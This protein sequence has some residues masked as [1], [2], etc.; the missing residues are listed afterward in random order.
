MNITGRPIY[1]KGQKGEPKPRKQL[2]AKPKKVDPWLAKV[3][4]LPCIICHEFGEQQL[5]RTTVHHWIMDRGSN[6]R[7]PHKQA[8]P[9]CDG[10]HQGDH[11]TSKVAI[12]REPKLWR[13]KYG[14]DHEYSAWVQDIIEG[15]AQL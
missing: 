6:R 13:E 5:S 3:A 15:T 12:H 10:H 8:L 14:A 9:L 7:T 1:Q 4:E 11:D 2:R